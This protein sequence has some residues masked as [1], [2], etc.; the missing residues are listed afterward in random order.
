MKGWCNIHQS[1]NI[2]QH[3][4]RIKDKD[5]HLKR[6]RKICQHIFLI[7]VLEILGIESIFLKIIKFIYDRSTA[8]IRLNGEKTETISTKIRKNG[9]VSTDSLLFNLVP[10][11]ID[12]EK[13]LVKEN[14]GFK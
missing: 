1:I 10:C 6:F 8:N 4:N 3:I 2:L 13:S 12:K 5:T 9:I 7:K 14:R 11:L